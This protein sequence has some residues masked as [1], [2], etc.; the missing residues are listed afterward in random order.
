VVEPQYYLTGSPRQAIHFN[1]PI[2]CF[3]L[4]SNFN[5]S[6]VARPNLLDPHDEDLEA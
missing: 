2:F 6:L 1:R 3:F 5:P 4:H